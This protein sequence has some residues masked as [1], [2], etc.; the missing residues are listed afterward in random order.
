MSWAA[1]MAVPWAASAQVAAPPAATADRDGRPGP[2]RAAP[3]PPPAVAEIEID[4][5]QKQY[6]PAIRAANKALGLRGPA[7]DGIS[8]F[9]VLML[10]GDGQFASR[11]IP[12][13]RASYHDA[14]LATHDPHEQAVAR[15]TIELVRRARGTTYVPHATAGIAAPAPIDLRDPDGRRAAFSALLDD[16]LSAI[17]PQVKQAAAAANLPAILPVVQQVQSL[18]ELDQIANG[19]DA[20]TAATA[21]ALLDHARTLMATALK[22]M[23][24]RVNDIHTAAVQPVTG[25]GGTVLVNGQPVEQTVN[26]VNGLTTQNQA[27]LRDTIA[28]ANRIRDAAAT[29]ASAAAT[30]G[31]TQDWGTVEN[32]ATRVAGR[33]GD[34]LNANYSSTSVS[35]QYPDGYG[36]TGLGVTGTGFGGY[37][38]SSTYY[39]PG[40][41]GGVNGTFPNGT[42]S[43]QTNGP[44][45]GGQP[46]SGGT[47]PSHP[48]QTPAT[49]P[50]SSTPKSGHTPATPAN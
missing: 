49:P 35:T 9:Q 3:P 38:G 39:P 47:T 6:G 34:V 46:R 17:G 21:G 41:T 45:Y 31:T 32:D 40:A 13:A 25:T 37:A 50:A 18:M 16:E 29:F 4:L 36:N 11:A 42:T 24:T 10:R 8:R 43:G 12:A 5:Q 2:G 7:A 33:A 23:W 48:G 27:E 26:G 44:T 15:W 30:G 28:T 22:G 19:S 20:R 14:L 1:V